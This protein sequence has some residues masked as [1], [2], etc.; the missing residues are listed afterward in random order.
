ME[1]IETNRV[2]VEKLDMEL[3]ALQVQA[4]ELENQALDV[5]SEYT[6]VT[7]ALK[8]CCDRRDGLKERHGYL[9]NQL[10]QIMVEE[11]KA[12]EKLE[13]MIKES[14]KFKLVDNFSP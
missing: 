7:N 6:T 13:E 10:D 4:D 9:R 14:K 3:S 8:E 2:E 5:C 12:T 11:A 1:A